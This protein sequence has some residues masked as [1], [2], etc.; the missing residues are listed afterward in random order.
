MIGTSSGRLCRATTGSAAPALSPASSVNVRFVA[1]SSNSSI[2]S[3]SGENTFVTP[4]GGGS[5]SK[6]AA[7]T[8]S[9]D[10]TLNAM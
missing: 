7:A 3:P 10:C 2:R 8:V 5:N 9:S 6:P 4:E 1:V